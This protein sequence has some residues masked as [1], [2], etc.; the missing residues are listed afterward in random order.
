MKGLDVESN[1]REHSVRARQSQVSSPSVSAYSA[2]VQF[3]P[4]AKVTQ[5]QILP[6]VEAYCQCGLES[7]N[8]YFKFPPLFSIIHLQGALKFP[9]CTP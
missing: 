1:D 3:H 5:Y 4:M 6:L 9:K 7:E 2:H 8:T